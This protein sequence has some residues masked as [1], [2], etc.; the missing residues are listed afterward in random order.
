MH[1][2]ITSREKV[3]DWFLTCQKEMMRERPKARRRENK[4]CLAGSMDLMKSQ[5]QK[6]P[7]RKEINSSLLA[8]L[9]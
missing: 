4:G 2:N 6:K 8:L 7:M 1:K 3:S 5:M 9:K